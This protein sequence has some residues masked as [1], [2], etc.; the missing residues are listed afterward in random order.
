MKNSIKAALA[1]GL[2]LAATRARAEDTRKKWQLGGGI[3]YWST[4]DDIRSNSTTAFAPVDPTQAGTLPAIIF[5]DP[6]PDANELNQPTI[7]DGWKMDVNASFG[8][9]RWFSLQLGASYYKGPV[10]NIEFYSED[11][12]IPIVALLPTTQNPQ[13]GS[14]D[15]SVEQCLAM[16][17]GT[18]SLTYRNAFLPVG[19][20][21]EVPVQITGMVRFRPESPFDPYLGGGVGYIFTGLDTSQSN[22]ST[23]LTITASNYT[24]NNHQVVMQNFDDVTDFTNGLI[25]SSIQSGARGI[26]TF[27][28][29]DNPLPGLALIQQFGGVPI[30]G[31]SATVNDAPEVHLM[32]GFDYYFTSHLSIYV[33]GRYLW[34]R[35]KVEVRIDDQNQVLGLVKDYGCVARAPGCTILDGDF[36]DTSNQVITNPT[37]DDTNDVFLIQGGDIRLGGFSLGIG[38]KYTF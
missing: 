1:V 24:G 7:Q 37:L 18:G 25:V 28:D 35:S 17:V 31:L 12:H 9:T 15:C 2:L 13:D 30:A 27:P 26:R 8:F 23:P 32:G 29:P 6:R 5:S 20:L 21:T 10:G 33:D 19:E 3:S 22:I 11:R 36:I 34:A 14:A 38:F 16:T 4:I